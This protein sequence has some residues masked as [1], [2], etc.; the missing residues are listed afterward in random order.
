MGESLCVFSH[1][2]DDASKKKK[3]CCCCFGI[4]SSSWYL[5]LKISNHCYQKHVNDCLSS[6]GLQHQKKKIW[7]LS[8]YRGIYYTLHTILF[9]GSNDLG[10]SVTA[11]RDLQLIQS[12]PFRGNLRSI[13]NKSQKES[14]GRLETPQCIIFRKS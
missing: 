13:E 3:T 5:P 10:P 6:Y 12:L 11:W 9:F 8:S 14:K 1:L 7:C 4:K 2:L